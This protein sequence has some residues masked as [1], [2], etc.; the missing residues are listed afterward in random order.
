MVSKKHR[1]VAAVIAVTAAATILLTGTFAWQSISQQAKNEVMSAVNPGGRLHDDFDGRNK[2]VYVE[3]FTDP[4]DGGVPLYARVRLDEYMEIGAGAGQASGTEGK[5][6]QSLVDGSVFDDVTTWKTHIP[7]DTI[8]G[9]ATGDP[10]HTYWRW[11]TGGS[12]VFMPTFNKNKDSL[13]ADING[14]YEG[15]TPGDTIH[16]DDYKAYTAGE[17]KTGSA[18]YDAD[19]ND[20]DDA[21]ITTV[22]ETHTAKTTGTATILTMQD[23]LDAG[24]QPGPFWVWDKDG[25]AYWAE[26]IQPGEATGLLLDGIVL[27]KEPDDDWY[28]SI[29]VVGQ[30]AT[31]GDWGNADS[32]TGF[33]KDGITEGA[34]DLL[35]NIAGLNA[36]EEQT[37][38]TI[39]AEGDATKALPG[40]SVQFSV[41][42]AQEVE[43]SV[44]G[45]TSAD[46]AIDEN[47][48]L[49]IGADEAAGTALTIT[50]TSVNA[51]GSYIITVD[52]QSDSW[53]SAALAAITPGST[54]TAQIDGR[55]W[56][57]LAKEDGKALIMA[58]EM[59][60]TFGTKG[61]GKG[62]FDS[63][64]DDE[65][66]NWATS[67]VR[68]WLNGEYLNGLTTLGS[69]VA[70]TA[71]TTRSEF[72]AD[73]WTTS[74]DKVFL[75]SEADMAGT[76]NGT[77]TTDARDYTYG[78][79]KLVT[80]DE[81]RKC[82]KEGADYVNANTYWLRSPHTNTYMAAVC[83]ADKG[84]V[85]NVVITFQ[86]GDNDLNT[87]VRPA[88]WVNLD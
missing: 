58:K 71:I 51:S 78:N 83:F 69:H 36:E 3:N 87:G 64:S 40:G 77:A 62:Q 14:T 7:G 68:T 19:D 41:A 21:G 65:K 63:R 5:Q 88:M 50:A 13:K 74:Q 20:I 8:E 72:N 86:Y 39:T 31:L 60:K 12:T 10:F 52:Q 55:E 59:E 17:Q 6:A 44:S 24:A 75:L 18:I 28:Y 38:L 15:T 73:T 79:G 70:E 57:V 27:Q 22:E 61:N 49:T 2:D 30:F 25:W 33:Y 9:G 47:G 48:L 1:A 34:L 11:K 76:F 56:Y 80:N 16:F 23:W 35:N 67:S 43:W 85:E 53:D 26:P 54:D 84:Y 66:N 45:G 29:N 4:D 32:K 81:I 46:T 42:E 37:A 82:H